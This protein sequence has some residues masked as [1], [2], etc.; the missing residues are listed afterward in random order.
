[1]CDAMIKLVLGKLFI[2]CNEIISLFAPRST[3]AIINL[4]VQERRADGWLELSRS[5]TTAK[6]FDRSIQFRFDWMLVC[7][8]KWTLFYILIRFA[9]EENFDIPRFSFS[10]C[11]KSCETILFG[12]FVINHVSEC[13]QWDEMV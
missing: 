4:S 6:D 12:I 5:L 8:I 1:M 11:E 3:E 2:G 13:F 7:G 9:E 10:S